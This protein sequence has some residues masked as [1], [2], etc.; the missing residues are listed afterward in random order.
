MDDKKI[1]FRNVWNV[2]NAGINTGTSSVLYTQGID[3]AE[4]TLHMMIG[5]LFC[6]VAGFL[7]L[8]L[9]YRNIN[10]TA[11]DPPELRGLLKS[12]LVIIIIIYNNNKIV[13]S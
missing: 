3:F 6:M 8:R 9:Q 7:L 1:V 10:L 2:F 4:F 12:F 5:I 13:A 11:K